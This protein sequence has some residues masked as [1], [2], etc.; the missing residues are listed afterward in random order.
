MKTTKKDNLNKRSSSAESLS[1]STSP[2]LSPVKEE[3][4][5]IEEDKGYQG[6]DTSLFTISQESYI[7]DLLE[8]QARRFER[9][10]EENNDYLDRQMDRLM[11]HLTDMSNARNTLPASQEDIQAAPY[12]TP[13]H[14]KTHE[15]VLMETPKV[16][17]PHD[18][19][20]QDAHLERVLRG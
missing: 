10:Q 13:H 4:E 19:A 14:A 12:A 15:K 8:K 7:R 11:T 3:R 17:R 16:L 9:Q 2:L 5:H 20:Y 1:R 6:T 18:I